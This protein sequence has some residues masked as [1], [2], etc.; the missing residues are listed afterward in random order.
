LANTAAPVIKI[1]PLSQTQGAFT[2]GDGCNVPAAVDGVPYFDMPQI[3]ADQGVSGTTQIKIDLTSKGSLAGAST[4]RSS[5]NRWLDEA[6]M[7]S[8][9]LTR[10][11]AEVSN[12]QRVA[13]SYLYVVDF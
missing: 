11:T 13:G 12:C 7:R 3:A 1:V 8:A 6:A 2:A 10:F 5:G 9:R 4:Y